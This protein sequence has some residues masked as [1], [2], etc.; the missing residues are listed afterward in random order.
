MMNVTFHMIE[1]NS[2]CPGFT[3]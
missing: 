1:L 3:R 2:A